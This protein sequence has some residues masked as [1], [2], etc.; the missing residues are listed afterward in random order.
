LLFPLP[1]L[2]NVF[3]EVPFEI[4]PLNKGAIDFSER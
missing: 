3:P 4:H 2:R 1:F